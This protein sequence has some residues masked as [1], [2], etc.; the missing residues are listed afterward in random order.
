MDENDGGRAEEVGGVEGRVSKRRRTEAHM[1][2]RWSGR[3]GDQVSQTFI[4]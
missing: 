4:R 2:A 1:V 3:L